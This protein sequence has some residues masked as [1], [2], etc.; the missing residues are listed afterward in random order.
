MLYIV[1]TSEEA[2]VF[3]LVSGPVCHLCTLSDSQGLQKDTRSGNGEAQAMWDAAF[4][5]DDRYLGASFTLVFLL[6][7]LRIFTLSPLHPTQPVTNT[8]GITFS[9]PYFLPESYLRRI[10]FP[11][12]VGPRLWVK[13]VV[14]QP[15][16]THKPKAFLHSCGQWAWSMGAPV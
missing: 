10:S 3:S 11:S 14:L 2:W 13:L 16:D 7:S 6:R 12:V 4:I 9:A 8:R 15:Q 1:R 5:I